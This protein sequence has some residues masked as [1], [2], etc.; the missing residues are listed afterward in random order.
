MKKWSWVL[1]FKNLSLQ[2][3]GGQE[4]R[5]LGQV[6]ISIK[7]CNSDIGR[8]NML[9]AEVEVVFHEAKINEEG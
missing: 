9:P 8:N 1:Y 3:K 4:N 2:G 5:N 7:F 6:E